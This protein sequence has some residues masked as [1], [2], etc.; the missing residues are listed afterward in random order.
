MC[1][2]VPSASWAASEA[3]PVTPSLLGVVL[4]GGGSR[5]F[6]APKALATFR[7]E[8]LWA[9]ACRVLGAVGLPTLV[10]ANDPEVAR[11]VEA[12]VR[13]DLRP[14]EGPLAG[15]ET[16]LTEAGARG[17][18][19]ILVL[20]CDLVLVDAPLLRELVR[21]WPGRGAVAHEAP[22]RWG[23][24]PLCSLWSV[25]LL[26]VVSQA[27][28]LGQRSPGRLMGDIPLVRVPASAEA[29]STQPFRSANRPE[30]IAEFEGQGR[31][32]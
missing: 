4:A 19:G 26:P 18:D 17:M 32:R 11:S 25:E 9:R 30:D 22:G 23:V 3:I 10:L 15:I 12:E 21:S 28:E 5:R 20:A 14:G 31:D 8:A 13:G 27:L 29:A 6:G 7:G 16:G 1:T 24:A 2:P